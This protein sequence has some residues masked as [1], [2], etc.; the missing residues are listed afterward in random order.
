MDEFLTL[1]DSAFQSSLPEVIRWL[2]NQR[3]GCGSN[4]ACLKSL[5]SRLLFLLSRCSRLL[6]SEADQ[7]PAVDARGSAA[8]AS[9]PG[10]V[11]VRADPVRLTA[12]LRHLLYGCNEA[13]YRSQSPAGAGPCG[14]EPADRLLSDNGSELHETGEAA[15]QAHYEQKPT[16]SRRYRRRSAL[17]ELLSSCWLLEYPRCMQNQTNEALHSVQA[18]SDR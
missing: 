16:R 10:I 15:E 5:Y 13:A 11:S 18:E 12:K 6:S 8:A 9:R 1:G 17:G 7:L 4:K 3:A 2:H 14:A